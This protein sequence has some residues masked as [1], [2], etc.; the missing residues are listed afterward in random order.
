MVSF[1]SAISMG[2]VLLV[3]QF[4]LAIEIYPRSWSQCALRPCLGDTHLAFTRTNTLL[5]ELRLIGF[6]LARNTS[7]AYPRT[8]VRHQLLRHYQ[9]QVLSSCSHLRLR[10]NGPQDLVTVGLPS[11]RRG[12]GFKG[13]LSVVSSQFYRV[14]RTECAA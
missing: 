7:T 1:A 10:R 3:A 6:L 13:R 2:I 14:K 9:L 12:W 8:L 5:P 4:C 11:T